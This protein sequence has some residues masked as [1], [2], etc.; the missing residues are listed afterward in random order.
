MLDP[1]RSRLLRL[2]VL[3]IVT[4]GS[5][6]PVCPRKLVRSNT[7]TEYSSSHILLRTRSRRE[8]VLVE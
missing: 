1:L 8:Q 4:A 7:L 5:A 3:D 2:L 6:V